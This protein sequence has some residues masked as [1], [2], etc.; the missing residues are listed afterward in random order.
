M[1]LERKL[2]LMKTAYLDGMGADKASIDWMLIRFKKGS[3]DKNKGE[4]CISDMHQLYGA[5]TTHY[6][7]IDYYAI[8]SEMESED[9]DDFATLFKTREIL[10][11][12]GQTIN[13]Y[14]EFARVNNYRVSE[15]EGVATFCKI[16]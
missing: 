8:V 6:N 13:R 2:K 14:A 12:F 16:L 3:L 1:D 5:I 15:D 11:K 7:S 4:E 10:R 9:Y